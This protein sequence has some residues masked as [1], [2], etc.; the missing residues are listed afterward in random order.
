M[1][2]SSFSLLR[3]HIK[4]RPRTVPFCQHLPDNIVNPMVCPAATSLHATHCDAPAPKL[5]ATV[6]W[7]GV[8]PALQRR[9]LFQTPP[10]FAIMSAFLEER[11]LSVHHWTD[12]LFSFTT[13]RD[14]AALSPTAISP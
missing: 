5:S 4:T 7:P 6:R 3:I 2:T 8:C 14:T 9:Q 11:V 10:I 13:T 12:R 1:W